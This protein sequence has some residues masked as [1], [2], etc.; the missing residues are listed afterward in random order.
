MGHRNIQFMRHMI[1][2][3]NAQ[4]PGQQ[5]PDPY[6]FYPSVPNFPQTNLQPVVPAPG[7]QCNFNIHPMPEYHDNT[8]FYGMPPYNGVPPQYNPFWHRRLE[9][10]IFLFK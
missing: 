1:D 8:V 3:E 4:G 5:P 6:I 10:E 7:S 2:L 9:E